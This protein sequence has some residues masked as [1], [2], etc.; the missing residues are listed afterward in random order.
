MTHKTG[1][2]LSS[3][4]HSIWFSVFISEF[5]VIFI[6]NACTLIIFARNRQLLK[7]TTYLIINLTVA[8]LLVGA[9]TGPL[10]IYYAETT[11][12]F[13]WQEFIISF[14]YNA[15]PV[16]SLANLSLISLE[17]LHAT[18]HPFKHC[19]I[20]KRVYFIAIAC[21]WLLAFVL[22]CM[23]TVFYLFLPAAYWYAWASHIVLTLVTLT[24]SYV[25]IAVKVKSNPL[26]R[27]FGAVVS[28]RKLS[29][30][31]FIVTIVSILTTLPWAIWAI[32]PHTIWI[33]MSHAASI[34]IRYAVLVLFCASSIVNP[35]VY[36]IRMQ[37]FR[38]AVKELI[39]K[40]TP[41]STSD[42]PI[43][44]NKLSMHVILQTE[45]K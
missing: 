5:T 4:E 22:A 3:Q 12:D 32:I 43:E 33:E 27:H 15:F 20:R 10:E 40:R 9:V 35:V 28:N 2:V 1:E 6:I 16:S 13:S 14:F 41:V 24:I 26:H 38:Q 17:R 37:Q 23:D 29:V 8:D 18:L 44:L 21:S 11:S 19:S 25:I 34:D 39:C 45:D 30:T 7:R 36:A 42:Q 31:L